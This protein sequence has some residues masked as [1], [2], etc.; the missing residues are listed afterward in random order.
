MLS[1]AIVRHACRFRS[2]RTRE[3]T[4]DAGRLVGIGSALLAGLGLWACGPADGVAT[5][6]ATAPEP[7]VSPPLSAE[8]AGTAYPLAGQPEGVAVDGA[9]LVAVNVRGPGGLILFTFADPTARRFVRLD[10]SARH[11]ELASP[12]GPLLVPEESTDHL[13]EVA[14][15]SGAIVASIGVGRQPHDA[16]AA[17]GGRVFVGDELA[18]TVHVV[19]PGGAARVIAGPLQPGGVAASADGSVVVVVGVRGRRIAAYRADGTTIGSANCGAGPTHVVGGD[20]LFWVADTNG[21]AV[22]A[23]RVRHGGLEQVARIAVGSRPY[24]LAYDARRHILWVTVTATNQLV[25][26]HLR[27]TVT[28]GRTVYPTVRQPNSVA[29]DPATGRLVVTGSGSSGAVELI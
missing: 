5:P 9:S 19:D 14:V 6:L 28:V 22:V 15:P 13:V 23:F 26:L 24:G 18:D 12:S 17:G 27:G 25:G 16:A 1:R 7:A 29:V 3:L 20:G 21:G 8:P 2:G 4:R 11:L 10:G